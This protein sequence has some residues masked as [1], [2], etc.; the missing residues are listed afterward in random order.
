M[1]RH[2]AKLF[3]LLTLSFAAIEGF[4]GGSS[5]DTLYEKV[6]KPNYEKIAPLREYAQKRQTTYIVSAVLALVVFGLFVKYFKATGALVALLMIAG[7]IYYLKTQTPAISPY[8]E[9]FAQLILAPVAMNCCGYRYETGKI[10]QNDIQKSKIF[11]PR[12]KMLKSSEGLFVKEG[13]KFG[14]V[15]I[16]FDTKEN[17]SV[18][19]FAENVFSGFVIVL[20]RH[21][22]REGAVISEVFRQKVA[23]IDPEFSAFFADMPRK[24]SACGFALFGDVEEEIVDRCEAVKERLVAVSF[25]KEKLYIFL[26]KEHNPLDPPLYSDFRFAAA[27]GYE[28]VFKEI[29]QLVERCR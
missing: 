22:R 2:F 25:Q 23:D 29:D 4:G 5:I 6:L 21:N 27:K 17:A 15:D 28:A 24:G 12:I 8:K 1:S 7:G 9:K 14:Y 16:E 20:D 13:V 11:A 10:T 3:L 19:R 26:Y 18:E